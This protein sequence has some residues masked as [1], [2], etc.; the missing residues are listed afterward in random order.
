MRMLPRQ[1]GFTL[2]ELLV[3]LSIFALMSA[4]AYGGLQTLLE[5]RTRTEQAAKQFERLQ[6]TMLFLQQD[7][8]QVVDREVRD[9]MGDSEPAFTGL[10][11][12]YLLQFT[13]G[14]AVG[15]TGTVS[16][17]RI[18]YRLEDQKLQ[19]LIWP[20]LDRTQGSE[21]F[22]MELMDELTQVN[23]RFLDE[24]WQADWV[25]NDGDVDNVLPRAVEL[26]FSTERWGEIK[27]VFPVYP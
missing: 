16:L 7:L 24:E 26:S 9:E 15:R 6:N 23:I 12:E 4:M 22:V 21:P 25:V 5:S 19:R 18:A 3:A 14:G 1:G 8:S 2:L 13:R 11:T 10:G 20:T 17:Q 27:R